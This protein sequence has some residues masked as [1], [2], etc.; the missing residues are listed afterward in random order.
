MSWVAA[1]GPLPPCVSEM[2]VEVSNLGE[3]RSVFRTGRKEKGGE[4]KNLCSPLLER[5]GRGK[6]RGGLSPHLTHKEKVH[7]GGLT[8]H[9]KGRTVSVLV[10]S[11]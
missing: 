11:L 5:G 1:N 3:F 7:G 6:V 4:V 10:I 2:R 8:Q 9:P